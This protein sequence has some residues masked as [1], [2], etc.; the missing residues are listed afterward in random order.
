MDINLAACPESCVM[1]SLAAIVLLVLSTRRSDYFRPA[2]LYFLVQM[3]MLGVAYLKLVPAMTDFRY[4]TWL[5]WG[6][7]M[8]AFIG[9][10]VLAEM[11]WVSK[12][13]A[14]MPETLSLQGKYS[15]PTHF[16]LSFLAFAY[17]FIGVAG[18]VSVAGNLVLLTGNPSFWLSGD[19][20]ALK[21]ADYFTS[22]AMVVG[23]FGVASFKSINP[24]RWVRYA[25]RGMVAFTIVL[26]FLTFPSR[27]INMLC[28]GFIFLLY[29]YLHRRFSWKL[30]MVAVAFVSSTCS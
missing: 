3:V 19:S 11:A 8:A 14:R 25:S 6:G 4:T 29:N 28:I 10:A 27:G 26:S 12:G 18:V 1:F 30:I 5:V 20:P 24:V 17:F 13:G 7:G 21:Y 23:L 15:W 9:G 2:V 22:G 16:C